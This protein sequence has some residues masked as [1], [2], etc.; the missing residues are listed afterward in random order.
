MIERNYLVIFSFYCEHVFTTYGSDHGTNG[1]PFTTEEQ[2]LRA[3]L[4]IALT[5][6]LV[7]ASVGRPVSTVGELSAAKGE[8]PSSAFSVKSGL[9][10]E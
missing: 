1:V 2:S 6:M 4:F 10:F 5:Q 7:G 9:L 3:V 8:A